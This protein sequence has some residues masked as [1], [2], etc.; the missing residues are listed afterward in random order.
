MRPWV[1]GGDQ[2]V[3]TVVRGEG[4]CDGQQ[5]DIEAPVGPWVGEVRRAKV[6]LGSWC[7]R[8]RG[9]SPRGTVRMC[10]FWISSMLP[11]LMDASLLS[12]RLSGKEDELKED[13]KF[14]CS[15]LACEIS[16]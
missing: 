13:M 12:A 3:Y 15:R 6:R 1:G 9:C 8:R 5:E 10:S 16:I 14:T 2:D 7:A 11:M 4:C